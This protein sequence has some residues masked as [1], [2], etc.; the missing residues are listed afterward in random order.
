MDRN[1]VWDC[2]GIMVKGN[3][4]TITQNTI[5]D[6]DPLNFENLGGQPRDLAVYGWNDY[7]TCQCTDPF[8]KAQSDTCCVPG[9]PTNN[10]WENSNSVITG[11]G[12]SGLVGVLG[13]IDAVPSTAPVGSMF[14]VAL[15]VKNSAGGLYEQLRDPTNLDFRPRPASIWATIGIGA[16]EAVAAG[17]HYW[18]P[19]RIE[20]LP[21][22]PVPPDNATG[23]KIDA[24]LMFLGA[25]GALRSL[26]TSLAHIYP[27]SLSI[28]PARFPR[29]IDA[30]VLQVRWAIA[31]LSAW[32]AAA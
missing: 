17:S 19:G 6:T 29:D 15:S 10:T 11:N 5:F 31:C 32:T 22:M 21:S 18:I 20:W 12:M 9:D 23:V 14:H 4:H 13:G 27:A 26:Q 8:C 25:Y 28:L 2:N 7:G 30:H 16:Y 3:N 24:D 1:V